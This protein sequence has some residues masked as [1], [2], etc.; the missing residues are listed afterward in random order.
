[1]NNHAAPIRGLKR[2][3]AA[4]ALLMSLW[5]VGAAAIPLILAEQSLSPFRQGLLT[6]SVQIGFAATALLSAMLQIPDRCGARLLMACGGAFAAIAT[7]A[8]AFFPADSAF[9]LLTRLGVGAGLALVYPIGLKLAAT[10]DPA[11]RSLYASLL[12]AALTLGSAAPHALLAN[13]E[14]LDQALSWRDLFL[15][16]SALACAGLLCVAALPALR[17]TRSGPLDFTVWRL[18]GKNAQ[19]RA[20]FFGYLG[21]MWEL[22]AMWAWCGAMAAARLQAEGSAPI[23]PRW[24]TF[25]I[26]ASGSIGAV[27]AGMI[28]QRI[29]RKS[30]A[31]GILWGGLL[32]AIGVAIGFYSPIW[33]FVFAIIAWGGLVIADSALYSAAAAA[34]QPEF[35]GSILSLQTSIGFALTLVSIQLTGWIGYHWGWPIA[36]LVLAIGSVVALSA[37]HRMA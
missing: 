22:Y 37:S 14:G 8:S 11:R 18:A 28:A 19:M 16:A 10:L 20:A 9:L 31:R 34:A 23:D 1:M 21:H 7:A 5:F 26:M 25:A 33:I 3:L 24:L 29:G 2:L 30:T 36:A 4:T 17:L 15:W 13:L 6:S 12:I 35:A 27:V 32:A